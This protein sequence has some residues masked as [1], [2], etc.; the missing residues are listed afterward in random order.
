[1]EFTHE[2]MLM[3]IK[4]G[5]DLAKNAMEFA[6]GTRT[7]AEKDLYC[8]GASLVATI[9]E[10]IWECV[11]DKTKAESLLMAVADILVDKIIPLLIASFVSMI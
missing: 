10:F 1:M 5:R 11:E 6:R 8:A 7:E 9:D 4:E 2:E 3:K